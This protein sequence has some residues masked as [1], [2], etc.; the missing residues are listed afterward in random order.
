[1]IEARGLLRICS[2][3]GCPAAIRA[4][5]VEWLD[6]V[7]RSLPTV[8]VTARA[9]GVDLANVRVFI[10]GKL[11]TERLSGAALEVDPG[12]H[13]FRFEAP[14]WPTV[15]RNVLVSE[16]VKD[17]S[18]DVVFAPPDEAPPSLAAQAPA[19]AP[20]TTFRLQTSDYITGGVAVAALA[21]AGYFGAT[22]ISEKRE[23]QQ[24]C[25]PTCSDSDTD[26]LRTKLLV[27]D[28]ALGVAFVSLVIGVYLHLS[29]RGTF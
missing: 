8:V 7:G 26:P 1:L 27:A 17:R 9:K 20:R 24:A 4:D 11:I 3:A 28:I 5:C 25:A 21:T 19:V 16:G 15:E 22:A 14:P 13:Q 18:I 23:L 12:Q 29:G 10:D 2:G 6:Q